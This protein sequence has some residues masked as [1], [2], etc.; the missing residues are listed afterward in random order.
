MV[1]TGVTHSIPSTEDFLL[2][3]C[4]RSKSRCAV[5][6]YVVWLHEFCFSIVSPLLLHMYYYYEININTRIT[7]SQSTCTIAVEIHKSIDS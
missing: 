1:E 3:L 6:L 2:F 5:N 7:M 4:L